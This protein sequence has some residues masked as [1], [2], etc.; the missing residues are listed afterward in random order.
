MAWLEPTEDGKTM[1]TVF[2]A[3]GLIGSGPNP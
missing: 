2:L 1:V 3:S